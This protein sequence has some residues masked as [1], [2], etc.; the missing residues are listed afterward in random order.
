MVIL[1]HSDLN[2]KRGSGSPISEGT[3]LF[4]LENVAKL[5]RF[6]FFLD[7]NKFLRQIRPYLCDL[8]ML[9]SVYMV[10]SRQKK[11]S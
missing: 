5:M 7:L 8:D 9:L 4:S 10:L 2:Q 3:I 11:F 6:A 1:A